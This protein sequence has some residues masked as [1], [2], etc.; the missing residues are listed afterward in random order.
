MEEAGTITPGGHKAVLCAGN[1]ARWHAALRRYLPVVA[2][3]NLAWEFAHMPLYTVWRSG[4]WKEIAFAAVHCTG[5]DLLIALSSLTLAVLLVGNGHWPVER[6]WPVAVTTMFF[7]LTCTALS[8][9]LNIVRRAAWAYSDLMPVIRVFDFELGL[10]PLLQW[11]V[12][13]LSALWWARPRQV[14][15]TERRHG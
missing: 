5:G 13:P 1:E 10:S 6:F 7:G 15:L 8:E 9:W 2:G 14:A 11:V 4:T 12:V 3:G